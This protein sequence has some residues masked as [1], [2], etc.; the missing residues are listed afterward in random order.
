[1][2]VY[3]DLPGW[4]ADTTACREWDELPPAA[5]TY[6]DH[7]EELAGVR[8]SLVSVGPERDQMIV[9][10]PSATRGATALAP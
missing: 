9:R 1:E 8:I 6:V 5:R 2:P 10:G 7:L 4:Q 3:R